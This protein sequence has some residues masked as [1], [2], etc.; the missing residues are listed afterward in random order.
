MS[1]A[2]HPFSEVFAST[3]AAFISILVALSRRAL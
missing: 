1:N 3:C 2:S